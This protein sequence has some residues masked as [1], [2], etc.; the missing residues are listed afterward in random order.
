ELREISL[1]YMEQLARDINEVIHLVIVH[2]NKAT[3]I[4]KVDSTRALRLYT[5]VGK[6]LPLYM[7]SGPQML[8]A[9]SAK[10]KRDAILSEES[11]ST[12]INSQNRDLSDFQTELNTIRETGYAYSVGEQDAD[13][14]GISYPIYN[15]QGSVIAAIAVS[16]L[17]SHFA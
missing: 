4:E 2:Q 3:Y 17:S 13:T 10:D 6:R 16:G 12:Y 5:R 7:G 9:F 15:H 11:F 1:P 8:L 14:T